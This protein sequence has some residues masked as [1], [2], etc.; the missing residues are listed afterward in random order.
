MTF[1]E[2]ADRYAPAP[3][4]IGP[5]SDWPRRRRRKGGRRVAVSAGV[6]AAG[7]FVHCAVPLMF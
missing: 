2:T 7:V 4:I 6:V 5:Y 1:A 3:E